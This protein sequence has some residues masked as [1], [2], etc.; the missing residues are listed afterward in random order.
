MVGSMA[1]DLPAASDL[2]KCQWSAWKLEAFLKPI[3]KLQNIPIHGWDKLKLAAAY[4]EACVLR[5]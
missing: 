1:S 2:R 4:A 3:H 5:S